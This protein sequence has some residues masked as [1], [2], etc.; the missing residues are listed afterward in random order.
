MMEEWKTI[1]G[2]NGLYE[3]S[4]M[5]RVR[6][7]AKKKEGIFLKQSINR[8]G[9]CRV[10]LYDNKKPK[11]HSVHRLV[12]QTFK[13]CDNPKMQVNHLDENKL[14]NSVDNLEWVSCERNINYGTRNDKVS[15][16]LTNH[17]KKCKPVLCVETNII[18]P[19]TREAERQTGVN[20][21][22]ITN[23]CKGNVRYFNGKPYIDKTAGGFHWQY[24]NSDKEGGINN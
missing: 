6:S 5:G 12:L 8:F 22:K 17:P 11:Y 1:E 3:V 2:Y 14:N 16:A 13:P 7:C 15:K 23:V 4:T 18:Y 20:H 21:S 9:Y 24:A 19:S 10:A